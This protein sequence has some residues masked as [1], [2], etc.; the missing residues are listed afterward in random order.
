MSPFYMDI[1]QNHPEHVCGM[2]FIFVCVCVLMFHCLLSVILK[3]CWM[4][5]VSMLMLAK[6]IYLCLNPKK[7]VSVY[8]MSQIPVWLESH[9]RRNKKETNVLFVKCMLLSWFSLLLLSIAS[10]LVK[11]FISQ[12]FFSLSLF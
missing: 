3:T 1:F 2:S 6:T 8:V 12:L 4:Y 5:A 7:Y 10:I 9:Y 11:F